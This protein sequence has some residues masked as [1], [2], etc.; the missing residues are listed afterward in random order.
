[1]NIPITVF[2]KDDSSHQMDGTFDTLPR[3]GDTIMIKGGDLMVVSMVTFIGDE[4]NIFHPNI[5]VDQLSE[6]EEDTDQV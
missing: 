3:V 4:N 2:D 5:T 1:M 6:E